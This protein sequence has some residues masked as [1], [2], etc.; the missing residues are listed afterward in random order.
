MCH[1][2]WGAKT[3]Y[4]TMFSIVTLSMMR[5]SITKNKTGPLVHNGR[6]FL[7]WVS[8]CRMSLWWMSQVIDFYR[9]SLCCVSLG[10]MSLCWV[11]WRS[12]WVLLLRL[13]PACHYFD[14]HGVTVSYLSKDFWRIS[15]WY[16][17]QVWNDKISNHL[18]KCF[19]KTFDAQTFSVG[20]IK[21]IL[22][23]S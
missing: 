21:S 9:M 14:S 17:V 13:F 8:L 4:I 3:L 11:Q 19:S 2:C 18:K 23:Y 12:C 10:W 22:R 16:F 5:F 1:L 20:F 7:Y 15:S 6:V